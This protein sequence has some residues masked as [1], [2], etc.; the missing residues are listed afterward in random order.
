MM[1]VVDEL[2]GVVE[3]VA[4]HPDLC[5][6]YSAGPEHDA[7]ST[8]RDHEADLE[9]PGLS[10]TTL[11]PEPWWTRPAIDWI[12]RRLCKYLD[13]AQKSPDRQPWVLTGEIVG[14]GPDHE[15]LVAQVVPLAWIGARALQQAR[16]HYRDRFH[17][18]RD[19][20]S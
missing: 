17:V 18:G 6:R 4:E 13:L 7:S 15:P 2:A 11:R 3:L 16:A 12:A 5:V 19:S 1:P 8:S 9:L 14:Y 10:V 20:A